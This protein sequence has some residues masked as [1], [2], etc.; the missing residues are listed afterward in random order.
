M[1]TFAFLIEFASAELKWYMYHGHGRH[2]G[3]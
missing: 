1:H 2:R 3:L